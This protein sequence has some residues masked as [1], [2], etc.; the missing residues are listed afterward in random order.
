[1]DVVAVA[2]EPLRRSELVHGQLPLARAVRGHTG[3]LADD[4]HA[5]SLAAGVAGLFEGA[6]DVVLGQE[7]G[8][9]D[10]PVADG[11]GELLVQA[12]QTGLGLLVELVEAVLETFGQVRGLVGL[13]AADGALVA[14]FALLERTQ[15][16]AAAARSAVATEAVLV[17]AARPV[18]TVTGLMAAR[19]IVA[20][21][22]GTVLAPVAAAIVVVTARAVVTVEPAA[23]T[24]VVTARTVVT[25]APPGPTAG[26]AARKV[27]TVP[28]P[29]RTVGLTTATAVTVPRRARAMPPVTRRA[30]RQ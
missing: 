7:R 27:I 14:G 18:V 6:F 23:L 4:R 5:G 21:T 24:A 10:Q 22:P 26:L 29:P 20:V 30:L 15:G 17:V 28:V 25:V 8:G 11:L 12:A 1:R 2:A 3:D 9:G 19:A 16:V 13:A